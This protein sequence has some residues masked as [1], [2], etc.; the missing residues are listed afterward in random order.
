ML[1]DITAPDPSFVEGRPPKDIK[2]IIEWARDQIGLDGDRPWQLIS[3]RVKLGRT[4]FEI[5]ED[6]PEGPQRLIGKLGRE[7]RA[8]VLHSALV[9]LREAGFKP[10]ERMTV[11]K[12]F[13]Y[14]PERGLVL[15]EKVPGTQAMNLILQ[16]RGRGCFTAGDCA[17]WLC[18]LHSS[19]V[20]GNPTSIDGSAVSQWGVEL[21]EAHPPASPLL[22]KITAAIGNE[23]E[24]PMGETVPSHGDYH[25]MNIFVAGSNRVTAIDLDKFAN[26]EPESDIGWFLMQTAAF[27]FFSTGNF[28]STREPRRA[29]VRCYEAEMGRE[30]NVRRAALYMAMAFLK[31]LHFELV[32]LH[33]DQ[34]QYADP[35]LKAAE[36]AII[37][38]DLHP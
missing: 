5:E 12:P 7:E 19:D 17:R 3:A 25:P 35:W 30:I 13:A 18:A 10:P 29:F 4:L 34:T 26:R 31:N 16:S 38:G 8:E 24:Q 28:E 33:T 21:S 2:E 27:G 22:A 37:E 32:L 9:R 11:P 23:L 6:T 20:Q 36:S 15:Q 1:F 14:L